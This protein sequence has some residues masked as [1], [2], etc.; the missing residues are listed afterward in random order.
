[1]EG[2]ASLLAIAALVAA[3]WFTASKLKG[4]NWFLR[5]VAGS[6]IGVVAL[7]LVMTLSLATGLINPESNDAIAAPQAS[8]TSHDQP[9]QPSQFANVRDMMADF[10]DYSAETGQFEVTSDEPLHIRLRPGVVEGDLEEVVMA[11]LQRAVVYG[12]YK[13]LIHTPTDRVRVTASPMLMSFQPVSLTPTD[14]PS[15]DIDITRSQALAAVNAFITVDDLSELVT[16]Q[17]GGSFTY[18]TWSPAF[19]ELYYEDREPGLGRF[20]STLS[21]HSD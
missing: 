12:V 17:G 18:E 8:T 11:E 4:K 6:T 7:V 3:W 2:F 13:T 20:F 9:Y 5:H 1:M 10:N 19:Q 16:L 14:S 21:A 15:L